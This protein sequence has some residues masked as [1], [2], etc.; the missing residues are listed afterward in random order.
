M[1][2]LYAVLL[3]KTRVDKIVE[4]LQEALRRRKISPYLRFQ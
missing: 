4:S 3:M 2:Y 1:Q